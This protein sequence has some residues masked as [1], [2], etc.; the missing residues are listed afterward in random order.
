MVQDLNYKLNKIGV[1][2]L[3]V[4]REYI[5]NKGVI[6]IS[7]LFFF[8][9][10]VS[11]AIAS[12]SPGSSQRIIQT[13]GLFAF[14]FF[15]I[16]S[17]IFLGSNLIAQ[18]KQKYYRLILSRPVKR[19]VWVLGIF[20]GI[21]L[22]LLTVYTLMA[23]VWLFL[24]WANSILI[25]GVHI[26]ALGFI[27]GE[28]LVLA[29][30]SLFFA[31]FTSPLLHGFFVICLFFSGHMSEDLYLF[32]GK[33]SGIFYQKI[34]IGLFYCIP[35]FELLN[36][37]SSVI[38]GERLAVNAVFNGVMVVVMWVLVFLAASILIF[39]HRKDL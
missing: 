29:A 5:R 30:A 11:H 12:G 36:F 6:T 24:L 16:I 28:W 32:A 21:A 14:G 39:S 13:F 7:S 37:R 23:V 15:G 4:F 35:N 34:L 38:Y 1:I 2:A 10:I 22:L 8:V 9:L 27:F 3:S 25:T 19:S 33:F 17:N 20:T 31:A 18:I 26:A